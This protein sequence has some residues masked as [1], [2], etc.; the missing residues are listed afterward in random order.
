[1]VNVLALVSPFL[2]IRNVGMEI[3][4]KKIQLPSFL[5]NGVLELVKR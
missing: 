1:M 2:S 5:I 3:I 4:S